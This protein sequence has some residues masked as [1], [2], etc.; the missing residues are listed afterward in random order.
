MSVDW[1][2][3]RAKRAGVIQAESDEFRRRVAVFARGHLCGH[4][5]LSKR[6]GYRCGDA[7][8]VAVIAARRIMGLPLFVDGDGPTE[9]A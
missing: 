7:W 5:D 1:A 9:S 2:A 6:C 8:K 4:V 3:H